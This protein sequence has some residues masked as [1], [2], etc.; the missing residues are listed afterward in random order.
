MATFGT[1]PAQEAK[2][3]HLVHL[4]C[5]RIKETNRALKLI[6]NCLGWI[7]PL[8]FYAYGSYGKATDC[9]VAGLEAKIF[10]NA[11][12]VFDG[13]KITVSFTPQEVRETPDGYLHINR[14]LSFLSK[15]KRPAG[16]SRQITGLVSVQGSKVLIT[17]VD[18]KALE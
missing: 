18:V 6:N 11:P 14:R 17:E 3:W 2:D 15:E 13:R 7:Q 9:Y 5:E 8:A 12:E 4:G 16:A 10:A 1:W